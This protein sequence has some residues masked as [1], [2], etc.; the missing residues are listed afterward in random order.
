MLGRLFVIFGGMLVIALC[1]LLLAPLFVD[2]AGYRSAFEREASR[3]TGQTVRVE[4]T[5]N[6]RIL[7]FP[8]VTFSNVV[9]DGADGIPAAR[10]AAFSMDAELAPFLSGE[11]LIFDMRIDRPDVRVKLAENGALL[12][13]LPQSEVLSGNSIALESVNIS[14]GRVTVERAGHEPLLFTGINGKVSAQSLSG[15]WLA[16][17]R[18]I[19]GTNTYDARLSTGAKEAGE[20]LRA[21]LLLSPQGGFYD[22]AFDGRIGFENNAPLYNG[23]LD[24]TAFGILQDETGKR[25]KIADIK[26]AFAA[27]ANGIKITEAVLTAGPSESPY[28]ADGSLGLTFGSQA[29]FDVT[30]KGQQISFGDIEGSTKADRVTLGVPLADRLAALE[31]VL[32][33]IPVPDIPGRVDLALPAL[34]I[35]DTIIRN[36][37]IKAVPSK[38]GW[39]IERYSVELPGRTL[40]EGNGDLALA[41]GLAFSGQLTLAS[42]Q[43]TGFANWLGLKANDAIR[44]LPGAG[45]SGRAD[46]AATRQIFRDIEF[47]A[48]NA[49]LRGLIDRQVPQGARPQISVQLSGENADLDVF[50]GFAHLAS[51][52]LNGQ[53]ID[54]ALNSAPV[55]GFGFQAEKLGSVLR[56]EA[57]RL[58]I[59]HID[60][61]GL[62]GADVSLSGTLSN[63]ILEPEGV[64]DVTVSAIDPLPLI[65]ALQTRFANQIW[66]KRASERAAFMGTALADGKL[67]TKV[68]L[69]GN[70]TTGSFEYGFDAAGL[71]FGGDGKLQSLADQSLT[72]TAKGDAD[73]GETVLAAFGVPVGD[74]VT[75]LELLEPVAFEVSLVAKAGDLQN[76]TLKAASNNDRFETAFGPGAQA[77]N[78][79]LD[80]AAPYAMAAGYGLPGAAF[81]LPLSLKGSWGKAGT[82]LDLQNL[83][84]SLVDVPVKGDLAIFQG[85]RLKLTGNVTA[86]SVDRSVFDDIIFGP[87][88]AGGDDK[89]EFSGNISL[90]FDVDI[91]L[92]A[93]E[94]KGFAPLPLTQ[95]RTRAVATKNTMRFADV[96]AAIAGGQLT[97]AA[98]AR[99]NG[100]EA[101][102]NFNGLIAG[103]DLSQIYATGITGKSNVQIELSATGSNFE[104]LKSGMVGSGVVTTKDVV[105]SGVGT[106][107][108]KGLVDEADARETAPDTIAALEMASRK[109]MSGQIVLPETQ[110]AFTI[111]SGI[112]RAP[113]SLLKIEGGTLAI[114]PKIDLNS[115]EADIA[116]QL[117]FDAGSDALAGTEPALNLTFNGPWNALSLEVDAQPLQGFLSQRALEREEIRVEAIQSALLEKQRLRR[118]NRYYAGLIEARAKA[119]AERLAESDR[120]A[121]E[122]AEREKQLIEAEAARL[123]AIEDQKITPPPEQAPPAPDVPLNLDGLLKQLETVP[124]AQP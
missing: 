120:L 57:G 18:F 30:L 101:I 27:D 74:S 111:T 85:E 15:P 114:E 59:D 33:Q 25:Q 8:S 102:I 110:S 105:V 7:P 65:D 104:N 95:V 77:F 64:L 68:K 17:G 112:A 86:Q 70:D 67:T 118:E 103:A 79:T 46:I 76:G 99:K 10:I 47:R 49:V 56:L 90:P 73:N 62:A 82:T 50:S 97:G 94:A 43:P 88:A 89:A 84:G 55:T 60:V 121:K 52:A 69:G 21:R 96:K 36:A 100:P 34:V 13:A 51:T 31:S 87:F 42:K 72:I 3:I 24:I 122:A 58:A 44:A 48:G 124:A 119:E 71:R 4:G 5:A 75:A 117:Q 106:S 123:K 80:D 23:K 16:D 12:W 22:A 28:R 78:L 108:F 19:H 40:V 115:G 37:E 9:I 26:G 92:A 20:T 66:L 35:G 61:S 98:E 1:S 116:A 63:T 93:D 39:Q 41:D 91:V 11:I 32:S 83:E 2:W 107:G 53:D 113:R 38:T 81:G 54:L 45:F 109:I 29:R 6:A 14:D